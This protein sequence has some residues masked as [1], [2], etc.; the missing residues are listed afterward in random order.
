MHTESVIARAILLVAPAISLG[1]HGATGRTPTTLGVSPSGEASYSISITVP[2]GTH[3]MT[4]QLAL[5]YGHRNGST[6]LGAGLSIAGLSAITRCPSTWAQD[7]VAR[8][9]HNASYD[10]FCLDGR[11]LRLASGT[12]YG[13][14]GATY[15]TEIESFS[16]ITSHGAAG[17]G[18]A[19]FVVETKDGLTYEYGKTD[20]SRI[21]SVGQQT[22]RAWAVNKISDRA[23]NEMLF[24]YDEDAT[25]GAYRIQFVRYTGNPDESLSPA[26]EVEFVWETK[27]TNEIDSGYVAGSL[28]KEIM[29]LDRINVRYDEALVRRYELTY[30]ALLSPA[31][32][33]RLA[34]L[35]ECA[36]PSVDCLPATSFSY[37]N[38]GVG[39]AEQT[40][41]GA[42]MPP[43]AFP[44]AID[45][46]GDGRD[47]LVY[48]TSTTA[49]SG[50]WMVMLANVNGFATPVNTGV[51]NHNWL[52][53]IPIDYNADGKVDL[54]VP[55]NG[56]SW[57]VMLGG[58]GGLAAPVDTG[59]ATFPNVVAANAAAADVNGDGLEDLVWMDHSAVAIR[60]RLREW[61]GTFSSTVYEWVAP[62]GAGYGLN[63]NLVAPFGQYSRRRLPD[64]DGDGRADLA[65]AY[66]R[67]WW[68]AEQQQTV[69]E[70]YWQIGFM[71]PWLVLPPMMFPRFLDLDGDGK[72]DLLYGQGGMWC[73]R[74]GTGTSFTAPSC[75][76]S[77]A[78]FTTYQ[79]V[80]LDWEGDGRED[81]LVPY[82]P[83]GTWYL[84][85]TTNTQIPVGGG[86]VN[87]TAGDF[88]GDGLGDIGYL[89]GGTWV[90]RP[91]A[92]PAP[93]F[94]KTA[95]DGFGNTVTFNYAPLPSANYT[96]YADASF[97]EQDYQG[98]LYVVNSFDASN[99]IGGIY[100]STYQYY[101]ARVH[102]Q[103]R[104][105]EG[106]YARRTHDDRNGLYTYDYFHRLF[107]YTRAL[108]QRDLYQPDGS[109]K[110]SRVVNSWTNHSYGSGYETR[111]LPYVDESTTTLFALAEAGS[112][113]NGSQISTSITENSVDA[114]TGT[115]FDSKT[116]TTEAS[117]AN[118][119][120]AAASY[121]R[122]VQQPTG[123]F[124]NDWT[125]WCFGR[126]GQIL[127][128]HSHNQH[129]GGAITRTTD[130]AWDT[131]NC[132]PTQLTIEP[133]HPELQV[134]RTL[135]HDGFGNLNSE[136][137][138]G[139]G[140][141]PRTTE[142]GWGATGQFPTSI[143]NALN[144]ASTHVWDLAKGVPTSA[145]DPNGI[146]VA[147]VYD[148][149][150]RR[151]RED[152]PDGTATTWSYQGCASVGCVNANN[153]MVVTETQLDTGGAVVTDARLY[154]DGFD[155]PTVASSRA[156]SGAYNRVDQ[157]Y[158]ALGRIS[159]VSAP[160]WWTACT[161][162][163]TDFAYDLLNRMTHVTRPLSDSDPSPQTTRSYYEGLTTRAVDP[164]GKQATHVANVLGG[165]ARSVDHDNYAQSFDYDGFG[166]LVRV[167]DSLGNTLLTNIFN[168]RGMRKEQTDIAAGN[169]LYTPNALG[170]IVS[171][172][173]AKLQVTTFEFDA[174]GRLK[175]RS[176]TEGDSTFNFG[177]SAAARNIGRLQSM[178]GPG[179]SEGYEYDDNGRLTKRT[180]TSDAT[181]VID[182]AYNTL[183]AL[184]TLIYPQ[185][186]GDRLQLKYEYQ[187]GHLWKV[188]EGTAGTAFWTAND[189]DARGNL[190]SETL[191]N[192]IQTI[193]GFDRVSGLIDYVDTSGPAGSIQDLNYVW[194][195]L[196][197]LTQR[198]DARQSL[199]EDF[200]YDNLHRLTSATGPDPMAAAYDPRGNL[201]SRSGDL[202]PGA[203][204][205]ISWYSFNLPNTISSGAN[206]SQFFY[207]PDRSRYKQV[208]SYDGTSV[209]TTYVGGLIEKVTAGSSI[210][211]KHYIAG[212]SGPVAVYTR[213]SNATEQLH[214]LT[215]DHVGSVDAVTNA[216]GA[217]VVRLSYGAF[218][219]RRNEDT[220]NGDP[221][222]GDYSQIA[223]TTRRGYTTHE[224]LDNLNLTHMN[225]RVYDP[226]SGTFLSADPF[227]DGPLST[228]GWNRYAYVH[229]NPLSFID[230][231][232]FGGKGPETRDECNPD[233]HTPSTSGG[234]LLWDFAAGS[235]P[236]SGIV[237][238]SRDY[239][240]PADAYFAWHAGAE[241]SALRRELGGYEVGSQTRWGSVN[242]DTTSSPAVAAPGGDGDRTV[243]G[244]GTWGDFGFGVL[245]GAADD[246]VRTG[247]L[248]GS[249]Q[250]LLRGDFINAY[251][252]LRY[253]GSAEVF[254]AP[255]SNRGQFGYDLGPGLTVAVGGFVGG[256]KHI[257]KRGTTYLYQK[258][259][260][261]GEHLKFGITNNPATRY[262]AEELAGG[263]LRILARGLRADMLGLERKLHE[264]LPI[265]PEEAQS[266]YIQLQ[267]EKGLLPP[268]L[269]PFAP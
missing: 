2:P 149:F 250:R 142:I 136:T 173:D 263:R 204:T 30:E 163:W 238:D 133:G 121:V 203:S 214:Y 131:T 200:G 234:G 29:R 100:T 210:A 202:S 120:Q 64:F 215:R 144:Q 28:V 69:T 90:Y 47:D 205:S 229:N 165:L 71:P 31:G 35:Q 262:T 225:G 70:D 46:N 266:F 106:F 269:Y 8:N 221:P 50:H 137:V 40:S 194:N 180:I 226:L 12:T 176:E 59:T 158:D 201:Y 107:P 93:D 139:I 240:T 168:I 232:G 20:D 172:R 127:A 4:P 152:R 186:L 97:P 7:G 237:F 166:N 96:K 254:G 24:T 113:Y 80:I 248:A 198:Q 199:T 98:P 37:E 56:S 34:S 118:G 48:V 124:V 193:R 23:G 45:V 175:K 88:N 60:Y 228:Q 157:E 21:E 148:A 33:S 167:T 217:P 27:P 251:V 42:T 183:G 253:G 246:A 43:A 109:T 181:Y 239:P 164:L 241:G 36:G 67:T 79:L 63:G 38:G 110:I 155:R 104:G 68:D 85:A 213:N 150:G 242:G 260:P 212:G 146:Q 11:K 39:L 84:N 132:R 10:R 122:H 116:T 89:S 82:A 261:L 74:Y 130:I 5:V 126:P 112:G 9:V 72:D 77:L 187:H 138:V 114:A 54:L 223:S 61:G 65:F 19:H 145:T 153:R 101:G 156:L 179:Y 6:L 75:S 78:N 18:P 117:T 258:V 247:V 147:W 195:G 218:G 268:W 259:G 189:T 51:V 52:G 140:M 103:G 154:T 44:F 174:L 83:T 191:G 76:G 111:V 161:Q 16:R 119:A 170:E 231:S 190:I 81:F 171:Q 102:R 135:G 245:A 256:V 58:A 244:N 177:A 196:G 207:A 178:S 123:S 128:I 141:T 49:G 162:Y 115:V 257:A 15:R 14:A 13:S 255:D 185:T 249:F 55:Y 169:W 233:C 17:N 184:D 243:S 197:N 216:S 22:A 219:Q 73:K 159:R 87:A 1:A 32:R 86:W 62:M 265:G 224:M 25:N 188:K 95:T 53:A 92:G 134:T 252:G 151:T 220:W 160:C 211:W 143:E 192:G 267:V 99:G 129:G 230:P 209:Q 125:N 3:G 41:S 227:I 94:L 57:W 208:A 235:S 182:Y 236:Y 91:H 206:S 105:F 26:Y 66:G 222:S 264:T 108:L